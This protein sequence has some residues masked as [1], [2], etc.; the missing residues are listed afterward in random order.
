MRVIGHIPH[1]L[2]KITVFKTDTRF[3]VQFEA[4]S[5]QQTFRFRAGGSIEGLEDIKKL[6]DETMCLKVLDL[7]KRQAQIE[8]QSIRKLVQLKGDQTSDSLPE[9]I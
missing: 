1:P 7:L 5:V 6:V 2:L 4:G 8:Q 3:P 9:I